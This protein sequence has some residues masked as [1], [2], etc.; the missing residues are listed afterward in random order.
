MNI[1]EELRDFFPCRTKQG[2]LVHSEEF[3]DRDRY[4]LSWLSDLCSGRTGNNVIGNR[5]I[6]R[7]FIF[8]LGL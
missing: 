1:Y 6:V 5:V 4:L 3:L 7:V 2:R 8:A